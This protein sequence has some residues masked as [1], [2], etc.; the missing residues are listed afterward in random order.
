MEVHWSRP[1]KFRPQTGRGS[2]HVCERNFRRTFGVATLTLPPQ[3]IGGLIDPKTGEEFGFGKLDKDT[4]D[5]CTEKHFDPEGGTMNRDS[6]VE[7]SRGKKRSD[8]GD[9]GGG[10]HQVE[11]RAWEEMVHIRISTRTVR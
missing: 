7:L 5:K 2:S 4:I 1:R 6:A 11:K 8:V 10:D 9:E 3:A